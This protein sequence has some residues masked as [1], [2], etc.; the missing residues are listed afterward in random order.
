LSLR[1]S[2]L[3]AHRTGHF[4]LSIPA[5]L[6]LA[7][8]L[9]AETLGISE[10]TNAVQML[11][12]DWSA[13][14]NDLWAQLSCNLV[15]NVIYKRCRFGKDPIPYL[16]RHGILH[17]RDPNYHSELNST[18]VFLLVDAVADLWNA[19]QRELSS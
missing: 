1:K 13:R 12:C 7:E 8:G 16:H 3:S 9:S 14:D 6:P 2:A 18:R 4:T 10:Q 5:L 17:G 19:K 11:L 15:L